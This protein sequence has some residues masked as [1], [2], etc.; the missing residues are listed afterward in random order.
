MSELLRAIREI[1]DGSERPARICGHCGRDCSDPAV[2]G[3]SWNTVPICNPESGTGRMECY[4]LIRN[5]NHEVP[6]VP[7]RKVLKEEGDLWQKPEIPEEVDASSPSL[8]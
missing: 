2:S 5:F 3:S 8:Q 4:S 7:C 1:P 6:C